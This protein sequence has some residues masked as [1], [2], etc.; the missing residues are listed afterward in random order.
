MRIPIRLVENDL[1]V[2]KTFLGESLRTC[3]KGDKLEV[4]LRRDQV[5]KIANSKNTPMSEASG[6]I[7]RAYNVIL[8]NGSQSR[9]TPQGKM[10][11]ASAVLSL[12]A[13]DPG[14]A[15]NLSYLLD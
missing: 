13:I 1:K 12:Y 5:S 9:S 11:L 15:N 2:L 6:I 7:F 4:V 10:A 8:A 14:L 3:G